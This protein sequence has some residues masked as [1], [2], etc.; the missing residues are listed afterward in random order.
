MYIM[1]VDL[2]PIIPEITTKTAIRLGPNDHN[3][4]NIENF[5]GFAG[6]FNPKLF[7]P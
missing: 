1:A 6:H 4:N 5:I 2:R 3:H 7:N